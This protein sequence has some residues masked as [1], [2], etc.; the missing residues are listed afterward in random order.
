MSFERTN[1][2]DKLLGRL[3]DIKQK[4]INDLKNKE[5]TQFYIE[6]TVK[7]KECYEQFYNGEVW[8]QVKSANS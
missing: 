7:I 2:I 4:E 3:T 6:K 1:E 5:S 8:K